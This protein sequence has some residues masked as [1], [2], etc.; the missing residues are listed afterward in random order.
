MRRI[1]EVETLRGK[2][3]KFSAIVIALLAYA[4]LS[5]S[6]E[7]II[8]N[9]FENGNESYNKCKSVYKH[10]LAINAESAK[11]GVN[12][13]DIRY[14]IGDKQTTASRVAIKID[15]TINLKNVDKIEFW[16][17]VVGINE[18]DGGVRF[19][20]MKNGKK[21]YTPI[22]KFTF[23]NKWEKKSFFVSLKKYEMSAPRRLLIYF[24]T[25]DATG[26]FHVKIDDVSLIK[27]ETKTIDVDKLIKIKKKGNKKPN[28]NKTSEFNVEI[29]KNGKPSAFVMLPHG[30]DK[31]LADD[32]IEYLK[33]S[34][35]A[36]LEVLEEKTPTARK[37]IADG[38]NVIHLGYDTFTNNLHLPKPK[39]ALDE[40]VLIKSVDDN[41]LVLGGTLSYTISYFLEHNLGVRWFLP[42]ELGEFV[43]KHDSISV[44]KNEIQ[45]PSFE[46]RSVWG[47]S[48]TKP[49]AD[50]E[51]SP[52]KY[53]YLTAMNQWKRRMRDGGYAGTFAHYYHIYIPAD[54]YFADHPEYFPLI[55]GNRIHLKNANVC[56]T[57]KNVIKLCAKGAIEYLKNNPSFMY[58]SMSPNDGY[59]FCE[60]ENCRSLDRPNGDYGRRTLWA[61]NM[62]ARELKKELPGKSIAFYAYCQNHIPPY[63][64]TCED[65]VIPV[66]ARYQS[67]RR[68][69]LNNSKIPKNIL[70]K[71]NILRWSALSHNRFY[72]REYFCGDFTHYHPWVA[73]KTLA[74]DLKWYHYIGVNGISAEGTKIVTEGSYL[75]WYVIYQLLW[76]I[77]TPWKDIVNEY[78]SKLYG[79]AKVPM[80][81]Y[82]NKHIEV[83]SGC[84]CDERNRDMPVYTDD[85]MRELKKYLDDAYAIAI[86]NKNLRA[87]RLIQL[88]RYFHEGYDILRK[89]RNSNKSFKK[90]PSLDTIINLKN[91]IKE[92]NQFILKIQDEVDP[93]FV[94]LLKHEYDSYQSLRPLLDSFDSSCQILAS[95]NFLKKPIFFQKNGE[96]EW[97]QG[98]ITGN[99]LSI[100][101][102]I[103]IN[104]KF[105]KIFL[106]IRYYTQ[107][108]P[109]YTFDLIFSNGNESDKYEKTFHF[110][111]GTRWRNQVV[112]LTEFLTK[113]NMNAIFM[114]LKTGK[115][116]RFN[117]R[118]AQ[119]IILGMNLD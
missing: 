80:K 1:Y 30:A 28:I 97:R 113:S 2:T 3:L 91:N 114:T 33:K 84:A 21:R 50:L 54:K 32:L 79:E 11:N 95:E 16:G 99:D 112:D 98:Y 72:I 93:R 4:T 49:Y 92:L 83:Y 8:L 14:A 68:Y 103:P 41:N 90:E 105:K 64:L 12:G 75:N 62:V 53:K 115:G 71:E 107:T 47:F 55:N 20:F 87:Q 73:V 15:D 104:E 37:K 67:F 7:T 74:E 40:F 23:H 51:K 52:S 101:W 39:N 9:N 58:A 26:E 117:V 6:Q 86:K 31:K 88:S 100:T 57:N 85:E 44:S 48:P 60:C 46:M 65:N 59:L 22:I 56:M 29:I 27:N 63:D 18:V 111:P 106:F 69:P 36:L 82:Y 10:K 102:K 61:A 81:K 118:L 110:G 19:D 116:T 35:G 13:L 25:K 108:K 78:I 77:N 89:C 96:L 24:N 34:T 45:Y 94:W 119:F 42:G 76:N 17:R 66:Y 70:E 5:Y 43:P 109:Q 38:M